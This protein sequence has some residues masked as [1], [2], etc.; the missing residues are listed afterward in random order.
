VTTIRPELEVAALSGEVDAVMRGI[1]DRL[2]LLPHADGASLSTV[3]D[4]LAYFGVCAG[5]D[6]PLEGRTF[7]LEDTLGATCLNGDIAVLRKTTGPEVDRCLTPGA[8]SIVLAPLEWDDRVRG[9][10]GVR[11]SSLEAF[12]DA[13]VEEIRMLAAGASI[14]LRNAEVIERLAASER[15]YRELHDRAADAIIVT[16]ADSVILDAN[17]AAAELLCGRSRNCA[18]CMQVSCSRRPSSRRRPCGP[19]SS[20]EPVSSARSGRSCARTAP[21][22]WSSTRAASSTTAASTAPCAT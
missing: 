13:G 10:L 22:S 15:N 6:R 3:D 5:T 4:E 16:D 1:V 20:R 12:D 18:A 14:A 21:R 17:D 11:S 8:A 9:V 19:K 7:R 2:M